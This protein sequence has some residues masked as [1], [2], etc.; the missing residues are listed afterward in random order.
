MYEKKGTRQATRQ[1]SDTSRV[2]T[3]HVHTNTHY[4][5]N[6]TA[7]PPTPRIQ[8]NT[9]PAEP[10]R[11]YLRDYTFDDVAMERVQS[12][13]TSDDLEDGHHYKAW[14]SPS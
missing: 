12:V 2:G 1:E 4:D 14:R 11:A 6:N 8:P 5:R 10:D 9:E 3:I 7:I 13:A